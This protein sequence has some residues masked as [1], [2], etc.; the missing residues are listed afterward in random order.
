MQG[1][2][3]RSDAARERTR[4]KINHNLRANSHI[5]KFLERSILRLMR[6]PCA[7]ERLK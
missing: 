7:L 3:F 1:P 2:N 6:L 5:S 4:S